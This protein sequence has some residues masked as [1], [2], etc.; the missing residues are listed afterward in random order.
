[1]STHTAPAL[2]AMPRSLT[3][4]MALLGRGAL[5]MAASP[6]RSSPSA[7]L[8][9]LASTYSILAWDS[10][11]WRTRGG[12]MTTSSP[13]PRRVE[14]SSGFKRQALV[15]GS[16]FIAAKQP[17]RGRCALSVALGA[18]GIWV[19]GA[20][21]CGCAGLR[22]EGWERAGLSRACCTWRS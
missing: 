16:R 8:P 3:A 22:R 17:I 21:R 7:R 4:V 20:S 2:Q 18:P 5:G 11:R 9:P 14:R 1:M 15:D 6:S 12:D 19:C 10:T 13:L